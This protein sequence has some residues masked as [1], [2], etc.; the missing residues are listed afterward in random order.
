MKRKPSKPKTD[1]L[2]L[3]LFL[4]ALVIL[5]AMNPG[6]AGDLVAGTARILA[7]ALAA[8]ADNTGAALTAA[9]IAYTWHQLRKHTRRP[10]TAHA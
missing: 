9:G 1:K 4:A 8:A 7:A 2:L 3:R 5:A 10:A 6:A